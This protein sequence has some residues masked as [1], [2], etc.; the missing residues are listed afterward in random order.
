V[1]LFIG[2]TEG[3]NLLKL[4]ASLIAILTLGAGVTYAQAPQPTQTN[5]AVTIEHQRQMREQM[6]QVVE[7]KLPRGV[8]KDKSKRCPQWEPKIAAA[9]LP[10]QT[11]SYLAWR[12]ARCN[13]K[14][15][16][17]RWDASGRIVWTLNKNGSYDS[18]L[19]Q[20]NSSWLS[21]TRQVCGVNTGN[22]RKD[23]EALYD[24]DCSIAMA[25]WLMENTKG[26]LANWSL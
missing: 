15:V 14:A 4:T 1:R 6:P 9:G 21:A 3:N 16:N 8:P 12:E 18:G 23:L 5:P 24:V 19:F 20:H 26:K 13:R 11:F 2:Q 17:A 25:V 7:E 10:V 22:K